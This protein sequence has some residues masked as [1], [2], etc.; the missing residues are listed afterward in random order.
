M[1]SIQLL[2]QK[3]FRHART[4]LGALLCALT[5]M[6]APTRAAADEYRMTSLSINEGLSQNFAG[7][8]LRD[9]RGYL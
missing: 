5:A 8:L 6:L 3:I 7:T 9:T 4:A 2:P 1:I